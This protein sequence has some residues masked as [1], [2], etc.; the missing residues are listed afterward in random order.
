M[1]PKSKL[2]VYEIRVRRERTDS[3]RPYDSRLKTDIRL[4]KRNDTWA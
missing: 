3:M 1:K 2:V 4:G